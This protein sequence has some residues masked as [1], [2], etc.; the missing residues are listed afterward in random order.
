MATFASSFTTA[1]L[2]V[3]R[4]SASDWI[5]RL[6]VEQNTLYLTRRD[7][8]LAVQKLTEILEEKRSE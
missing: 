1:P 8:I 7:T 6:E 3:E 5:V 4:T 2:R